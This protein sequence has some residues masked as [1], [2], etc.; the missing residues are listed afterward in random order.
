MVEM[1]SEDDITDDL[2]FG[3]ALDKEKQEQFQKYPEKTIYTICQCL[4]ETDNQWVRREKIIERMQ[5]TWDIDLTT[6]QGRLLNMEKDGKFRSNERKF[7]PSDWIGANLTMLEDGKDEATTGERETLHR[8]EKILRR[9]KVGE[10][11]AYRIRDEYRDQI[12]EF[13][14]EN[15]M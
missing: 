4:L 8:W 2:E 1:V 5:E 11:W 6:F 7:N 13:C 15:Q 12:E 3:R 9:K 10:H 14:S